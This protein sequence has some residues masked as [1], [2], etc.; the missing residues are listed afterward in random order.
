MFFNTP[1]APAPTGRE[2]PVRPLYLPHLVV[3][4]LERVDHH[5]ELVGYV[6]LVRIEHDHNQIRPWRSMSWKTQQQQKW[7]TTEEAR[8][9]QRHAGFGNAV[10]IAVYI[11]ELCPEK[12]SSEKCTGGGLVASRWRAKAVGPF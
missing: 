10:I 6:Q 11:Q 5:L 7:T 9:G 2:S 1:A 4:G 8:T 3:M 12:H